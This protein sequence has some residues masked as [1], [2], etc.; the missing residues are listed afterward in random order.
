LD[1]KTRDSKSGSD[2]RQGERQSLVTSATIPPYKS[3]GLI[4][5]PRPS[6]GARETLTRGSGSYIRIGEGT[7]HTE[8]KSIGQG[9]TKRSAEANSTTVSYSYNPANT[10]TATFGAIPSILSSTH[11]ENNYTLLDFIL[12]KKSH[13][14]VMKIEYNSQLFDHY[15]K[16]KKLGK[17]EVHK[18]VNERTFARLLNKAGFHKYTPHMIEKDTNGFFAKAFSQ[19][20]HLYR[21]NPKEI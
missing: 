9:D 6:I 10:V 18:V 4:N 1:S 14:L 21:N 5:Y 7:R 20:R 3:A 8:G 2:E 17:N 16:S 12:R 19:G 13:G 15:F 11:I